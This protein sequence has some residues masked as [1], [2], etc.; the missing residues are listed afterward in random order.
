MAAF[1]G[2]TA[3]ITGATGGVGQAIAARVVDAGASVVLVARTQAA[4]DQLVQ[5]HGWNPEVVECHPVDL[6]SEAQ[7]RQFATDIQAAHPKINLLVHAA[8]SLALGTLAERSVA[9]FD[10][11][12]QVNVRAPYQLTQALLSQL[13]RCRGQVVF[14]NSSA[15]VNARAGVGQYAATKHALRAVAD[16]FR[17]EVNEHGVRVLSVFLGRTASKMQRAVHEHERRP[18]DPTRLLQPDDVA[19]IVVAALQ[20]PRSADVTDVHIRPMQKS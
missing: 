3:I 1:S 12:Y 16:S 4:L 6:A 14:I 10:V 2:Q 5:Q 20:I 19:S 7:V 18:Y 15:G 8:G 13:V 11:Q 17:D 9:E